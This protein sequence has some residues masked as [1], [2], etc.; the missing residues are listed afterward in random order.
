[1]DKAAQPC[2]W[3]STSIL[4]LLASLYHCLSGSGEPRWKH[5]IQVSSRMQGED[6]C[7]SRVIDLQLENAPL[8]FHKHYHKSRIFFIRA[9]FVGSE[10]FAKTVFLLFWFVHR[11]GMA[12]W[13]CIPKECAAYFTCSWPRMKIPPGLIDCQADKFCPEPFFT[14]SW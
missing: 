13:S 6:S 9:Q 8:K 5:L 11:G 3:R 14:P 1:M 2:I 4:I 12:I 7:R 10:A